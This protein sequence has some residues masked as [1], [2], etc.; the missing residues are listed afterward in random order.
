MNKTINKHKLSLL[1]VSISLPVLAFSLVITSN[2]MNQSHINNAKAFGD[3]S[4][5][6]DGYRLLTSECGIMD[7]V[8]LVITSETHAMSNEDDKYG[9]YNSTYVKASEVSFDDNE[10]ITNETTAIYTLSNAENGYFISEETRGKLTLYNSSGN[11]N[12]GG[13]TQRDWQFNKLEGNEF[14]LC[15]ENESDH[16][17]I[18]Y[19]NL[20]SSLYGFKGVKNEASPLGLSIYVD[21][22][23]VITAWATTYLNYPNE[24]TN[25]C[26]TLFDTAKEVLD[27]LGD[28]YKSC[29]AK[30]AQN[31]DYLDRYIAWASHLHKTI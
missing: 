8:K 10:V 22:Q 27:D 14:T 17:Y 6:Y 13:I 24:V 31:K 20:Q 19:R 12:Y 23:S 4:T 25:Q 3:I 16:Y 29:L 9:I 26:E 18:G 15:I 5:P 11:I 30:E 21:V 7:N 28:M 1:T 2:N